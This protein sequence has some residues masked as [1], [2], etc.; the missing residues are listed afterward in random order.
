MNEKGKKLIYQF[1][2]GYMLNPELNINKA[3]KEKV[4]INMAN[5]F[6]GTTMTPVR[7]VSKK[8]N[9]RVLSL[10]MLYEYIKNKIFKVLSS[11]VFYIMEN[12][13]CVDY[14]CCP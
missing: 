11:I 12:Y 14:M 1:Q 7:K 4:E 2:V 6:S 10:L 5:S 9:N 3:F 13:V 8:G